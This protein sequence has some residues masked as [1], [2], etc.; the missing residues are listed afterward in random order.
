MNEIVYTLLISATS[1]LIG[2]SLGCVLKSWDL[3]RRL[4][5]KAQD[6]TRLELGGKL[7]NI[8]EDL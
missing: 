6:G 1:I 8:K 7:Y 2:F 5:E 3:E 4:R